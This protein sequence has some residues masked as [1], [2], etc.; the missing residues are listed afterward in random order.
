MSNIPQALSSSFAF[1][2][3]LWTQPL[4]DLWRSL[5][6]LLVLCLILLYINTSFLQIYKAFFLC[7][8]FREDVEH[9][10]HFLL[11]HTAINSLNFV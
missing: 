4:D 6:N 2:L 8:E 3:P 7:C 9:F 1:Q 10:Y 11:L 5:P